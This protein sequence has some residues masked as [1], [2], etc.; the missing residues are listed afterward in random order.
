MQ[1]VRDSITLLTLGCISVK[2][3]VVGCSALCA[4]AVGATAG[5]VIN[6]LAIDY[7]ST[8]EALSAERCISIE[9]IQ[10]RYIT[11]WHTYSV[12]IEPVFIGAVVALFICAA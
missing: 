10:A 4:R 5:S 1:A 6:A 7:I 8:A 12:R 9:A 11:S 2:D 3:V